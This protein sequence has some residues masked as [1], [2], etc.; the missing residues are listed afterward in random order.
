MSDHN[1]SLFRWVLRGAFSWLLYGMCA[2]SLFAFNPAL[3]FVS[4]SKSLPMAGGMAVL[5]AILGALHGLM[6]GANYRSIGRIVGG[7]QTTMFLCFWGLIL[8][9]L[10]FGWILPQL[11]PAAN[12]VLRSTWVRC[13]IGG[14]T[15]VLAGSFVGFLAF[16]PKGPQISDRGVLNLIEVA[17]SAA[18]S[19]VIQFRDPFVDPSIVSPVQFGLGLHVS[20]EFRDP[21]VA[22]VC[23]STPG[24]VVVRASALRSVAMRLQLPGNNQN[25]ETLEAALKAKG[26]RIHR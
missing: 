10:T 4:S 6:G 2:S 18:S 20:Q 25:W 16:R 24:S 12:V 8:G 23:P 5:F 9:V 19:E 11:P 26:Y 21:H 1:N 7:A 13:L 15:G 14:V 17:M 22:V 3:T